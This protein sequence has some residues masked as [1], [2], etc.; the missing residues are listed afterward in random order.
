[1]TKY[2]SVKR[3]Q[4][5][6]LSGKADALERWLAKHAPYCD[7]FQRHLDEGTIEQAYWH[8]GYICN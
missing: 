3:S 5:E 6:V 4:I 1:M 2:Y 8:Y 7:T